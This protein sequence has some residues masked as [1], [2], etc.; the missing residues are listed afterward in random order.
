[1]L[2]QIINLEPCSTN[3]IEN[4]PQN[5]FLDSA[6]VFQVFDEVDSCRTDEED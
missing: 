6:L 2:A 3:C 4:N 1:M 5:R